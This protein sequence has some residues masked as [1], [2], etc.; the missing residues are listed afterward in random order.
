MNF[1]DYIDDKQQ[2]VDSV[3]AALRSAALSELDT[4]K[5]QMAGDLLNSCQ[6]EQDE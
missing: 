2:F 3:K 1:T 4:M 5:Q 6:Q